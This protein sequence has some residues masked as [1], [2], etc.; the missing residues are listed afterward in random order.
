MIEVTE[1]VLADMVQALVC[2]VNPVRIYLFGSRARG[3]ARQDSD[4]DLLIVESEPFGPGRSRFE[5][6]NRIH[7]ALSSFRVP[8]DILVYSSEEFAKWSRSLNH[9]VGHCYREGKLLY[10]RS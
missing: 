2:E 10:A 9:V 3:D 5:E 7:R 6:L 1:A 8:K 4:V